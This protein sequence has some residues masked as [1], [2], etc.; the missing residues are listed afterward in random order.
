M[1]GGG[2][3]EHSNIVGAGD[4]NYIG[5]ELTKGA[6]NSPVVAEDRK[7]EAEVLF[8]GERDFSALQAK[9]GDAAVLAGSG[10]VAGV[11]QQHG[12]TGAARVGDEV[13]AGVGYAIHFVE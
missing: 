2:S 13:A 4:V 7:I 8:K 1:V 3:A 5:S 12:Q 11:H 6:Q 9:A 10:A